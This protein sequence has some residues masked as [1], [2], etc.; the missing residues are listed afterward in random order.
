MSVVRVL[1]V[2]DYETFRRLV[3]SFLEDEQWVQVVGEASDGLEALQKVEDTQPD[4]ILLDISLPKL[5]GIE[6]ARQIRKITPE[7]KIIFLSLE[8]DPGVVRAA[9]ATGGLGYLLKVD[10]AAELM[11]AVRTV[12]RGERFVSSSLLGYDVNE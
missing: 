7:C 11:A 10:M 6:A 2:D 3:C 4:V 9:L 1:V 8:R 5:N 12:I